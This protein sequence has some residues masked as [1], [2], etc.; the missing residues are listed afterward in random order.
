[1]KRIMII[2]L[3]MVMAIL[4][5][6]CGSISKTKSSEKKTID[7]KIWDIGGEILEGYKNKDKNQILS[8]FSEN[9]NGSF[10]EKEIEDSFSFIDGEIIDYRD[11][12]GSSG[13]GKVRDGEYV[14][15]LGNGTIREIKTDSGKVYQINYFICLIDKSDEKNVGV[16]HI[17][18]NELGGEEEQFEIGTEN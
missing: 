1:M 11:I 17:L 2:V 16:T 13:G 5:D 15:R 7:E 12:H 9:N 18:I 3:L 6:S 14:L 4:S 8:F 10:I